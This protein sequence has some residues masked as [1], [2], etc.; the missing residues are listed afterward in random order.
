MK[1]LN[2]LVAILT[3]QYGLLSHAQFYRPENLPVRPTQFE[4]ALK[5]TIRLSV[6]QDSSCSAVVLSK[7]GYVLTNIHCLNKCL[8][9]IKYDERHQMLE[10]SSS[11]HFQGIEFPNEKIQ[12]NS[13]REICSPTSLEYVA[14]E[15]NAAHPEI[16]ILGKGHVNLKENRIHEISATDFNRIKDSVEDFAIL[17]YE[18]ESP[19]TC[20]SVSKTDANGAVW[21]IGYPAWTRRHDGFDS[22]GALQ[23][24]SMGKT[25]SQLTQDL[26]LMQLLAGT[27]LSAELETLR[28]QRLNEL[29]M[30]PKFL[31]ANLDLQF[32][33]SGG[34]IVNALGE[35]VGLTFGAIGTSQK[36]ILNSTS[37]GLS[38]RWL[39]QEVSRRLGEKKA[40]EIFDCP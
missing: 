27:P 16:V 5:A 6:T 18:V 22:N 37:L 38:A 3:V 26:F 15:L 19:T 30:R 2:L 28:M 33:S 36:Q 17:K 7:T 1:R 4:R 13:M 40:A 12:K 24:I 25:R 21:A 9:D 10:M 34:S 20:L 8:E 14:W 23:Y 29:W 39:K 32:G 31:K 35:L 11:D